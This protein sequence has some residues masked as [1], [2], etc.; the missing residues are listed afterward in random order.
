M[1]F[2]SLWE[3]RGTLL[4]TVLTGVCL[5]AGGCREVARSRGVLSVCGNLP[6]WLS[7]GGGVGVLSVSRE[8]DCGCLQGVSAV[9]G[10]EVAE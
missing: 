8:S 9:E 6:V 7:S 3:W 1:L 5:T 4:S 10:G 2:R